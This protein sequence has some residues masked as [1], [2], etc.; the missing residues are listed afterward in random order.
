[1]IPKEA[2]EYCTAASTLM[3]F[4]GF[5]LFSAWSR[6]PARLQELD[7]SGPV[8]TSAD[9]ISACRAAKPSE[10]SAQGTGGDLRIQPIVDAYE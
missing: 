8:L 2:N 1:M 9:S 6:N 5:G 10:R 3:L 4:D 7:G